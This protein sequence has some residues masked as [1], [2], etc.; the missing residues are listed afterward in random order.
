MG[1]VFCWFHE[2]L[3][4]PLI[5]LVV[6]LASFP[7]DRLK[8]RQLRVVLA[9]DELGSVTAAAE[10]LFVTQAAI[11]KAIGELE[12]Q[13]G[14]ALFER[15][16]RGIVPTDAGRHV[17]R[18]ARRVMRELKSLAEEIELAAEG[19]S[20]VL[21]IGMQAVSIAHLLPKILGAMKARAPRVTVRL[22]EGTLPAV[23]RDLRGG[24]VDLAFGRMV[25]QLLEADFDGVRMPAVPYVVIASPLHPFAAD[26]GFAAD[27]LE[28]WRAALAEDWVLPLPGTPVRTY[29][30]GFLAGHRLALPERLV[31]ITSSTM[32]ATLLKGL[33]LLAISPINI[34]RE[35]VETGVA[36]I[37]P[38]DLAFEMEPIGLLWSRSAPL[39]P[40]A[41][42]FRAATLAHLASLA[43]D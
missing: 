11:S 31:E 33:P 2:S 24:R 6:P 26:H 41:R 43:E 16:G 23:L 3:A 39:K 28:G 5:T 8:L 27:P 19:G 37:L 29:F 36:A 9:V 32:L 1:I 40:S 13:I 17:I 20:G 25:P 14:T 35:W 4:F 15:S 30:A 42:I 7:I 10:H 21:T 34:A 22:A 12:T 38:L 18:A